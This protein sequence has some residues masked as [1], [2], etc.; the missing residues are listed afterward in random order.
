M[1]WIKQELCSS[2]KG[3][4]EEASQL[5]L[6]HE[7]WKKHHAENRGV[8]PVESFPFSIKLKGSDSFERNEIPLEKLL[9]P[10]VERLR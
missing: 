7:T 3:I 4:H 9:Q 1:N 10:N 2:H 6:S 8:S 5:G